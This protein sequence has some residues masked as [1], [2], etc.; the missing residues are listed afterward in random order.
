MG[1]TNV[2][3]KDFEISVSEPLKDNSK[4]ITNKKEDISGYSRIKKK[5]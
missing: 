3:K 1:I 2:T 5:K 4:Q